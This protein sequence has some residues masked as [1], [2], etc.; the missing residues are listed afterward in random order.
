MVDWHFGLNGSDF[1]PESQFHHSVSQHS[2]SMHFESLDAFAG[3]NSQRRH[4]GGDA[5]HTYDDVAELCGGAADTGALLIRRGYRAG[6]NFDIVVG[7]DLQRQNTRRHFLVYLDMSQP[8]VLI[9]STPC[10][11]MKGFAAL[12]RALNH[13][14]WENSVRLSRPLAVSGARAAGVQLM[15]SRHFI[16]EHPQGSEMWRMPAWTALA[17]R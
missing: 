9:I 17:E 11:G 13:A 10:T 5:S 4:T 1:E 2:R 3:W 7:F 12:N 16:A 14:A 8:T 15:S 6:P